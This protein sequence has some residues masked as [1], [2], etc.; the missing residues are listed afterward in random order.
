MK[1]QTQNK[2]VTEQLEEIRLAQHKELEVMARKAEQQPELLPKKYSVRLAGFLEWTQKHHM[3]PKQRAVV[4]KLRELLKIEAIK[5]VYAY[6]TKSS[7]K[8][9]R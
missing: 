1:K 5:P 7:V 2:L 3:T 6:Q 4:K 9:S 8:I